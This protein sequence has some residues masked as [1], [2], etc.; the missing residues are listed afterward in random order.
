[1]RWS[2]LERETQELEPL[3]VRRPC[4]VVRSWTLDSGAGHMFIVIKTISFYDLFLAAALLS[5]MHEARSV[6]P[7]GICLVSEWWCLNQFPEEWWCPLEVTFTNLS[8][9]QKKDMLFQSPLEVTSTNLSINHSINQS[10][11]PSSQSIVPSNQSIN[12]SNQ[13]IKSIKPINQSV[14]PSIN[15]PIN[16][17]SLTVFFLRSSLSIDVITLTRG[18]LSRLSQNHVG[19]EFHWRTAISHARRWRKCWAEVGRSGGNAREW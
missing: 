11:N 19:L 7:E 9:G 3:R 15:H 13:L 14:N 6:C 5:A 4:A 18:N 12:P 2:A 16:Q 1:M 8:L 10:I 17:M